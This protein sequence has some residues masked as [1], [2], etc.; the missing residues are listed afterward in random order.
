M[1]AL[2]AKDI[3]VIPSS[4]VARESAFSLGKRVIDTFRSSL[5]PK[6][7]DALVCTNDWLRAE[8]FSFYKDP[9]NDELDLY[10]EIEEIEERYSG[11]LSI[12]MC[13]LEMGE[14]VGKLHK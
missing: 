1:L 5:S 3:F 4:T 12:F 2:I 10:K 13:H 11:L 14:V 9:T 6:M 7:V 8:E